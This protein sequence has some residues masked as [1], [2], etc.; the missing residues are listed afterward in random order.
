M[1]S[2]LQFDEGVEPATAERQRVAQIIDYNVAV[3]PG[4][5]LAEF[6]DQK[7]RR[8]ERL[9]ELMLRTQQQTAP[10]SYPRLLHCGNSLNANQHGKLIHEEFESSRVCNLNRRP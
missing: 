2:L 7:V 5:A 8:I 10:W 6:P 9:A 3:A 1:V 4:I